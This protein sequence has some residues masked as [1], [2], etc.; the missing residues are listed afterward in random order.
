MTKLPIPRWDL[1]T[2]L[3]RKANPEEGGTLV[4]YVVRPGSQLTYL[5]DWSEDGEREHWDISLSEEKGL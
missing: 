3:Y 4:G 1:G 5:V 2:L